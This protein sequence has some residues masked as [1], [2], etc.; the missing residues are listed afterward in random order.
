MNA[1]IPFK[2]HQEKEIR[3]MLIDGVPYFVAKDMALLLGYAD[4]NNAIKRHCRGVVK[5]HPLYTAGG[6]QQ[7]RV[8][9]EADCYLLI[10]KSNAPFAIRIQDWLAEDVLPEI[11][12]TGY[13]ASSGSAVASIP[14]TFAEALRLAADQADQID[15]LEVKVVEDTPKVEFH[16]RVAEAINCHDLDHAARVI[17]TGRNRLARFLRD[18]SIFKAGTTP[19]QK[20]IDSGYFKVTEGTRIDQHGKPHLWTKTHITGKGLIYIEKKWHES[21]LEVAA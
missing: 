1:I 14:Q 3:G 9:N 6:V 17:G 15:R 12:R 7:V 4:T 8:I 19:Y 2:F 13:Y 11:R 21:L 10:F 16:D 20:Y 5:H 18:I